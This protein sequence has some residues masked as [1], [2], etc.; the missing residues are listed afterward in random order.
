VQVQ[1]LEVLEQ[2]A[3]L[4]LHDRKGLKQILVLRLV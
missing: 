4:P 2:D 3:A 1:L